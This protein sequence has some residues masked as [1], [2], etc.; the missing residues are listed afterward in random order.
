[1]PLT[2]TQLAELVSRARSKAPP[3]V[4]A[5][6][7]APA[8]QRPVRSR[9]AAQSPASTARTAPKTGALP[10]QPKE[11]AAPPALSPPPPT[12][13][14]LTAVGAPRSGRGLPLRLGAQRSSWHFH[15][16]FYRVHAQCSGEY[17]ICCTKSVAAMPSTSLRAAG[18]SLPDRRRTL[19]IRATSW[20]LITILPKG[21]QPPGPP[22]VTV[23]ASSPPYADPAAAAAVS[24][25]SSP[26]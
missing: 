15:R 2:S 8:A 24:V 6:P 5:P 20:R 14:A 7:P 4:S 13:G 23:G 22:P 21:W 19:M 18:G 11:A 10:L 17:S 3:V 1:M 9:Q 26:R 12:A 16:R 25:A